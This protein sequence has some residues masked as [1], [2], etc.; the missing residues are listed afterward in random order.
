MKN[1]IL[2]IFLFSFAS[3]DAAIIYVTSNANGN[4][5]SW[6]DATDLQSALQMSERGDEIWVA[7][8]TYF[9]TTGTDRN[10]SFEIKDGIKVYGGFSGRETSEAQ[11]NVLANLTVLSGEIASSSVDD[12]SYNVVYTKNVSAETVV[13]GFTIKGGAANATVNGEGNRQRCGGGWFNTGADS[14]SGSNPTI[15]NC[16]FVAN[17]A[18]EGA[19]LY[20]FGKNGICQPTLANCTFNNNKADLDGGAIFNNGQG[21]ESSPR[22]TNCSFS[23]N[24]ATYG[25]AIL[26]NAA[27]NGKCNPQVIDCTF[28]ANVSYLRGGSLYN[29]AQGGGTCEP[30]VQGCD[31]DRNHATVGKKTYL[32]PNNSTK[33]AKGKSIITVK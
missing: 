12:N 2:L 24:E 7:G 18:R 30:I 33:K 23:N 29:I 17:Y 6:A 8:G 3:L 5:T 13:D 16:T 9:P 10:A 1:L 22:I 32:S 27:Y 20:N 15:I 31:F 4:G 21:G 11:R 14:H 19:G 28:A 25:G 26:N